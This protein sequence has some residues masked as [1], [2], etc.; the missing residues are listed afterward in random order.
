MIKNTRQR[1]LDA[2]L[3][4]IQIPL[5]IEFGANWSKPHKRQIPILRCLDKEYADKL[6]IITINVDG[7]PMLASRYNVNDIPTIIL[8]I[9]EKEIARL[10]GLKNLEEIK[11]VIEPCL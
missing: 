2:L 5:L 11:T 8:I 9:N 3:P 6:R 10:I 7:N 4:V 1:D